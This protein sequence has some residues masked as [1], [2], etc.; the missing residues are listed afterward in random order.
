MQTV[1]SIRQFQPPKFQCFSSQCALRGLHP[2]SVGGISRVFGW[3]IQG[4]PAKFEKKRLAFNFWP[5][6]LCLLSFKSGRPNVEVNYGEG[7]A[8]KQALAN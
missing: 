7:A 2:L 5:L 4:A 8:T 3:D 6:C 1:K